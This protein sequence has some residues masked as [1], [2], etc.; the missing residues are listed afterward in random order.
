MD[1]N[2]GLRSGDY[3][4]RINELKAMQLTDALGEDAQDY[5]DGSFKMRHAKGRQPTKFCQL[6]FDRI[7]KILYQPRKDYTIESTNRSA[8]IRGFARHGITDLD[9]LAIASG[10]ALK[11]AESKI[12]VWG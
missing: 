11:T 6:V 5:M 2:Y 1:A 8:F 3:P 12:T 4:D 10:G 9:L 7:D